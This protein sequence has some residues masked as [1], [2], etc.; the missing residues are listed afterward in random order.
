MSPTI[1]RYVEPGDDLTRLLDEWEEAPLAVVVD[2]IAE[3]GHPGRIR[4]VADPDLAT[5]TATSVHGISLDSVLRLGAALGWMPRRL[6]IVGIEGVRFR[7]GDEM[8]EEVWAAVAPAARL[9]RDQ[10]TS[11]LP[12]DSGASSGT[13]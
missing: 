2:A 3:G 11:A 10:L 1:A 9:V 7:Q 8:S 4:L 6:V 13:P 5:A 12:A